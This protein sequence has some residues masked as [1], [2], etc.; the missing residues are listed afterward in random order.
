MYNQHALAKFDFNFRDMESRFIQVILPLKIDWAPFYSTDCKTVHVGQMVKVR[1]SS[2]TYTGV[3]CAIDSKPDMDSSKI[4][5]IISIEEG[6]ND[7]PE[8]EIKLWFQMADYYMC[9]VGEV[10]KA[11]IPLLKVNQAE[12]L[13][14]AAERDRLRKEKALNDQK[15]KIEARIAKLVARINLRKDKL[16]IVKSCSTYDKLSSEIDDLKQKVAFE[17]SQLKTLDMSLED[18]QNLTSEATGD[19]VIQFEKE[20]IPQL[21]EAQQKAYKTIQH[22]FAEGVNVLLEGVTGSGK[23]EIYVRLAIDA[24]EEGKDVLYL[25][26]EIALSR[27][28]EMRL[29]AV[30]GEKLEVYHSQRT[31][32]A[33]MKVEQKVLEGGYIVLGTRSALFLPHHN[34]GLIVVDEEHDS[35]YKQ[36]SPAPHYQGRDTAI[37]MGAIHGANVILGSAT[38]SLESIYNVMK[39]RFAGVKLTERYF[40]SEDADVELID[41]RAERKKRGMTGSFSRKLIDRIQKTIAA[42][43]QVAI[44]RARRSYYPSLQCPECGYIP[45]CPRCS[46]SLSLHKNNVLMCHHCEFRMPFNPKCPK[47]GAEMKGLGAGVQKIEE[48]AAALFPNAK[49][50]RLD[51]DTNSTTYATKT[52]EDFAA[53]NTDILIG[54]QI[55]TKGFDFK[56]LALVAVIQADTLLGLQDFRADEKAIQVLEQFKGRCGR[57]GQKGMLVIQT[58]TPEHPVYKELCSGKKSKAKSSDATCDTVDT[59]FLQERK[60]FL[61]PPYTRLINIV[62]KDKYEDRIERMSGW[63]ANWIRKE[64]GVQTVVKIM[65]SY[66]DLPIITGPYMPVVSKVSGYNIRIIRVSLAKDKKLHTIKQKILVSIHKFEERYKYIG[67]ITI[68]VDPA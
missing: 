62:I 15:S 38:P 43:G 29:R 11:A 54:T 68:D 45:R 25:V 36:D 60:D 52:I 9:T 44:L 2:K 61:F 21:T 30:F 50:A 48:E 3:V 16:S 53:G 39:G 32:A 5:P 59:T 26:P 58:N 66:A 28:L 17:Q 67:H 18:S 6:L 14:Q 1:F 12:K 24:L 22:H 19:T 34:L 13:A 41:T 56:S 8:R 7:I 4:I 51:G 23:T 46:V 63:L 20:Q 27:Q 31:M 65:P 42:G 55:L 10:Y 35:S 64:L 37:M 49:I 47:C 33:R 40:G 57:R